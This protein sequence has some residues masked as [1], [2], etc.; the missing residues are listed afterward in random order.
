MLVMLCFSGLGIVCRGFLKPD[1]A[2]EVDFSSS[3]TH[4]C[5]FALPSQPR[6]LTVYKSRLDLPKLH[7]P[8]RKDALITCKHIY[9]WDPRDRQSEA[10]ESGLCGSLNVRPI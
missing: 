3:N 5:Y 7:L 4:F 1:E 10:I 8:G 6:L 2:P 9:V